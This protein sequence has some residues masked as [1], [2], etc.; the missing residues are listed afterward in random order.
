MELAALWK[1][2]FPASVPSEKMEVSFLSSVTVFTPLTDRQ[3]RKVLSILHTRTFEP[4]EIIFRKGDPGVGMYVIRSGQV[5]VYNEYPDFTKT[6]IISL[7]SGDFFGEIAL[8]N[9]SPRSATVVATVGSTLLGLFRHDLLSLMDSD[10]VLGMKLVYRLAQIV[11]ERL[12]LTN[13]SGD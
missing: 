7:S 10:P 8:L 2:P 6:R 12:R 11:S 1:N 9:D 5:D 3:K 13:C 4:G